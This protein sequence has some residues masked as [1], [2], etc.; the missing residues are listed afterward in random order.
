MAPEFIYFDLDDT[1]LDHRRAEQA[2]LKDVY[3]HYKWFNGTKPGDLINTYHQ[4]NKNLWEQ[5]GKGKIGRSVLQRLRFENTL[6]ELG[7]DGSFYKEVG[8]FYMQAYQ[9]HWSWIKGA[10][11]ALKK[12]NRRFKTGILTNGFAE[13][14][15][16]K[17][18]QFSLQDYASHLVIS[19]E[20]GFLKP[21]PEIFEHAT[22]LAKVRPEEILYVGDSFSSDI[23]GGSAF[24]WNTAWFTIGAL[25][26]EKSKASFIFSDFQDLCDLLN[27]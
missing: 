23:L 10:F 21:R 12:I 15:K 27:V 13:T 24:G 18:E 19:E 8:G 3:N 20:V 2:A 25:P 5:Y 7:L 4:I 6:E 1:L 26:E 11:D 17:I 14:Q 16:K 22:L 9:S